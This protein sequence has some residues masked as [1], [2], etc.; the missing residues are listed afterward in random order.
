MSIDLNDMMQ[1]LCSV[2]EMREMKAVLPH[3]EKGKLATFVD[4]VFGRFLGPPPDIFAENVDQNYIVYHLN[5]PKFKPVSQII[6][7]LSS[8]NKQQL[9]ND[10]LPVIGN[11]E[12]TDTAQLTALVKESQKLQTLLLGVL[13]NFL[14]LEYQ[15]EVQFS[16]RISD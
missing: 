13:S 3:S 6:P 4:A 2:A 15:A 10:A 12:W 11:Q 1:L 14:L 5:S 8:K 9:Y 16:S 7:E